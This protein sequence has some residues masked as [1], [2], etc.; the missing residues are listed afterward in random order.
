MQFLHFCQENGRLVFCWDTLINGDQPHLYIQAPGKFNIDDTYH[1]AA[2]MGYCGSAAFLGIHQQ[3]LQEC[4]WQ[5]H[6]LRHDR[7]VKNQ[8][9]GIDKHSAASKKLVST[10]RLKCPGFVIDRY[11]QSKMTKVRQ[12]VAE[13]QTVVDDTRHAE[14]N[15]THICAVHQASRTSWRRVAGVASSSSCLKGKVEAREESHAHR[16]QLQVHWSQGYVLDSGLHHEACSRVYHQTQRRDRQQRRGSHDSSD[17]AASFSRYRS[18]QRFHPVASWQRDAEFWRG[19]K[20]DHGIL[21][22]GFDTGN[23]TDYWTEET[24]PNFTGV[25]SRC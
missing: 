21:T 25:P 5:H 20:L 22:V 14:W 12:M 11:M 16:G 24:F 2:D 13:C 15:A 10:M 23:S 9:D 1:Q 8:V 3:L 7:Q 4:A 18:K 17:P 6:C 19:T